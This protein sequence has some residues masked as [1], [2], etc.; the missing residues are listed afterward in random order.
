MESSVTDKGKRPVSDMDENGGGER[1]R[2]PDREVGIMNRPEKVSEEAGPSKSGMFQL[3]DDALSAMSFTELLKGKSC[4]EMDQGNKLDEDIIRAFVSTPVLSC[5]RGTQVPNLEFSLMPSSSHSLDFL[6]ATP[7]TPHH[8]FKS[9]QQSP[10]RGFPLFNWGGASPATVNGFR[11]PAE[12]KQ[13][14]EQGQLTIFYGGT[15]NVYNVS[16]DMAK[17]IMKLASNG[18]NSK[19]AS[20]ASTP[21]SF[22]PSTPVNSNPSPSQM[23]PTPSSSTVRG[24][25]TRPI[26]TLKTANLP[27]SRKNSLQRFLEKRNRRLYA[28]APYDPLHQN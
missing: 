26:F 14:Q 25:E 2:D 22:A 28:R 27:I 4:S 13:Q 12:S 21:T 8:Q 5:R 20:R 15:V 19:Q 7:N 10:S 18:G 16:T 1:N 3:E 24:I 23:C 6:P 17:S 11:G 9:L